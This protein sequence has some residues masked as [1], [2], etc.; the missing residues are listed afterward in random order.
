MSVIK[1]SQEKKEHSEKSGNIFR[2]LF[3][4]SCL[5]LESKEKD[6]SHKKKHK[7]EKKHRKDRESRP[8]SSLSNKVGELSEKPKPKEPPKM[9]NQFA[10]PTSQNSTIP[11]LFDPTPFKPEVK[12][13]KSATS[14]SDQNVSSSS[15]TSSKTEKKEPGKKKMGKNG[16]ESDQVWVC[17]VCSIAYVDGA[18]DMVGCDSW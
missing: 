9:L 15:S 8:A 2:S 16:K 7:K 1:E 4:D 13:E 17:P 5:L 6:K 18:V 12:K 11:K 3:N 10:R 14:K